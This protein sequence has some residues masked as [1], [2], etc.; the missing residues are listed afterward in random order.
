MASSIAVPSPDNSDRLLYARLL[1]ELGELDEAELEVADILD[2]DPKDLAAFNLFAKIKHTRGELSQA[3]AC[4]AQIHAQSPHSERAMTCL[5]A[6]LQ[7]ANDSRGGSASALVQHELGRN[8]AARLELEAAFRLFISHKSSEAREACDRL[9][10]RL[11]RKDR[12]L[13]KLAVLANAWMAELTGDLHGACEVLEELG[14]ERGFETDIDRVLA[15]ARVYDRMGAPELLEKAVR[16][17]LHIERRYGKMSAKGNLALLYR[18]LGNVALAEEYDALYATAFRRRMHRVSYADAARAAS[19]RFV[20]LARMRTLRLTSA[21]SDRKLGRRERAI[22]EFLQGDA[23]TAKKL[24]A[25]ND[26][27]LDRKYLAEIAAIDGEWKSAL[28]SM[29]ELVEKDPDDVRLVGVTLDHYARAP[30]GEVARVLGVA[31]VFDRI[32]AS[33]TAALR[34]SPLRASLW[35]QMSILRQIGGQDAAAQHH[36][37]RATALDA[38]SR[39]DIHTVGRVLAAAVFHFVGKPKGV[40]HQI[41]VDRTPVAPGQGGQLPPDDIL[42]NITTDMKQAVRNTF[43]SIREYA[44]SRFPAQTADI[45]D[46]NYTFKVTKEDEPSGGPSAGLPTALAFLSVFLQRPVP[47][48]AAFS[49][50]LIADAH[51]V[52]VVR[53]VGESEFKVKAAYNRNLRMLVLPVENK[54]DLSRSPF[55]P[56]AITDEI[57][58][59]ASD[60]DDA[61]V[62]T[63]GE[64]IWTE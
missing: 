49:G 48:D 28:A 19:L 60:I 57:V 58:A 61:V 31:P 46:Y 38:A 9:A 43:F 1:V 5:T 17:F 42:G 52:L 45:L 51:D 27:L 53:R 50:V 18:K 54:A 23:A 14:A 26:A 29:V 64:G 10:R 34:V 24:L 4:W 15:L 44:R 12:D 55:L 37:G 62:L 40:I 47:Q 30:E 36:F 16:I 22:L 21:P 56:A 8:P 39:R 7:V 13:Y 25:R 33:M 3:I 41:W 59:F 63:F 32:S 20:S 2:V 11:L 35:R 6:I